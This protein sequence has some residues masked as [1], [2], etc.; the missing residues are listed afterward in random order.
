VDL[1]DEALAMLDTLCGWI[2][3]TSPSTKRITR[4]WALREAI[5]ALYEKTWE[6]NQQGKEYT[7]T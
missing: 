2:Q 7:K 4:S 6:A 5:Q 1:G 3:Q